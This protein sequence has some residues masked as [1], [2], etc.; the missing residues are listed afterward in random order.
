[1]SKYIKVTIV[2]DGDGHDYVIPSDLTNEFYSD[3]AKATDDLYQEMQF[4]EKWIKFYRE[5]Y[6]IYIKEKD[7]P[8]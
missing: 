1:M 3:L 6:T 4:E 2:S 5:D 8:K 7:L